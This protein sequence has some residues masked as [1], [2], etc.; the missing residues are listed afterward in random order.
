MR[1]LYY[2]LG[3]VCVVSAIIAIV[4]WGC[5]EDADTSCAQLDEDV[6]AVVDG[7]ERRIAD[8]M[9]DM[10]A[11]ITDSDSITQSEI[12]ARQMLFRQMQEGLPVMAIA[13]AV[14]PREG[15]RITGLSTMVSVVAVRVTKDLK[16]AK[17]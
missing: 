6:I 12:A 2:I 8:V 14:A 1:K 13:P 11:G 16:F 10:P 15:R 3:I 7:E 5:S 17:I 4:V 9:R